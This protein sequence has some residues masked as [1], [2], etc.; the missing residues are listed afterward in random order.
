MASDLPE[1]PSLW[2]Q[3]T[4][5][6]APDQ[7]YSKPHGSRVSRRAPPHPAVDIW[8]CDISG[9]RGVDASYRIADCL[10]VPLGPAGPHL[11]AALQASIRAMGLRYR[12]RSPSNTM[13]TRMIRVS[14]RFY[15]E[16]NDFLLP[17]QRQIT[18]EHALN[19]PASVKHVI[20]AL[21][22]PHPEVDLILVNGESVDFS[23]RV[24]D[25]DWISVYP[26][27]ESFDISPLVRVRPHPLREPR[28]VL[29]VHL[30]TLAG[31]L[32]MLGFDALYRNDYHDL[33]LAEVSQ[34]ERRILLTRDRG[35]LMRSA[36]SHGYLV[37]EHDP[38][39]QMAEVIRRFDLT[40]A[41]RTFTRCMRCNGVLEPVPK[42]AIQGRLLP[43]TR[44]YYDEFSMCGDCHRIYWKGSHYEDM[45]RRLE[46]LLGAGSRK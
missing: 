32:R 25:G 34:R 40:G 7:G 11:T 39:A 10:D 43:K 16:L 20:E 30:G 35:L 45:L 28:F 12:W 46:R 2:R 6:R 4:V 24:R 13:A 41:S 5:H 42:D 21:G 29:D 8:N 37:R 36:V 33:E 38:T 15:A 17:R 44:R 23:Y 14:I 18:I 22:V 1:P 31:Y 26:V 27:F 3:A 19:G 9:D